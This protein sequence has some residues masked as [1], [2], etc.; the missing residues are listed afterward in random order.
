M[1]NAI[2]LA[3]QKGRVEKKPL[4]ISYTVCGD[5]NK[6]KSLEILKSIS[7]HVNIVEWGFAHN[8]PTADGPDIQNSSYRAIKNGVNLK[9]TFK[10]VKDYKK[11]KNSKPLILMGYY[12]MIFHYGE[13]R[14][15]KKCKEVGVDGLIVV[16]LPWPNNK[17]IAKLCKKNSI[18]FIQL[19]APTT[20]KKR[21]KM[22]IRDSHQILY[23]I[24]M[25]STTGKKLKVSPRE[26]IKNNKIIKRI[27]PKKNVVVGFGINKK[28]ISSL[29][30]CDGLVVGSAICKEISTSLKNRQNPVKKLNKMVKDLKRKMS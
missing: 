16:D 15:V 17:D 20:T 22:I 18:C 1:R 3:F 30:K 2:D 8:C 23:Q 13:K 26:I 14:F 25:I 7:E 28:N 19:V 11:Y 21:M 24:S 6:K 12:Q 5:P 9:D 29:K 10:L 4:L 27:N